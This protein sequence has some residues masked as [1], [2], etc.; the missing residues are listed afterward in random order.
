MQLTEWRVS[1]VFTGHIFVLSYVARMKR[2]NPFIASEPT[3][4]RRES[5]LS[6]I[7]YVI[8]V[9]STFNCTSDGS[10]P[11]AS[12]TLRINSRGSMDS[13][14]AFNRGRFGSGSGSWV[15][16]VR[17]SDGYGVLAPP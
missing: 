16:I 8:N 10:L 9:R 1:S 5:G 2:F 13:R 11:I 14:G 15:D 6:P 3:N 17:K 7:V 4:R 12:R